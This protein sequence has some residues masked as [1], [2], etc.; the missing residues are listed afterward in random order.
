MGLTSTAH[1][2]AVAPEYMNGGATSPIDSC[3]GF[4][5]FAAGVV[6]GVLLMRAVRSGSSQ[7]KP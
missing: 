3:G 7:E 4:F 1:A 5:Y 6:V 2:V